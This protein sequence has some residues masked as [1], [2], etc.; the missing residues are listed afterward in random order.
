M[1]LLAAL[2]AA[3]M[4]FVL[5]GAA[6]AQSFALTSISPSNLGTIV[7]APTGASTFRAAASTGNV[8]K[9][10][11][12]AVRISGGTVRSLVTVSCNNASACATADALIQITTSGTPTGRAS[13]LQNFTVSTSGATATITLAPGTGNSISF[14]IGP[15]GR[16]GSKTFWV[17]YD[18]PIGGDNSSGSTGSA[19][20]GMVVTVSRTNGNAP[21]QLSSTI[22]ATVYRGLSLSHSANLGFGRISLPRSGTGT[23][24]LTPA[25]AMS[26]TGPGVSALSA[27]APTAAVFGLSGEGGQSV[28]IAVPASFAMTGPGGTIN[29]TTNPDVSGAQVLSGAIGAAGTLG[30]RVG[31]S[32]TLPSTLSP[33]SYTGTIT[34]TAQYN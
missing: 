34:V 22:G 18:M 9:L 29:V 30:I 32:F 14:R 19:G 8:T 11:G 21:S 27:A 16:R 13:A 25:G 4:L 10:S 28:S 5:S 26:V 12:N 6:S 2:F 24:S 1:R 23:V 17:G 3:A 20:A 31:G 33:G 15:V 7:A